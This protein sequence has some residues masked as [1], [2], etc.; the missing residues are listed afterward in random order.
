[1]KRILLLVLVGSCLELYGQYLPNNSQAFQFSPILNPGFSGIENFNDLKLSYRYQWTSFGE[2]SPTFIN[3]SYNTRIKKP[4]DLSYN[5]IRISNSAIAKVPRGKRIIHG[6]AGHLFQSSVGVIESLGAGATYAFHYPI[7]NQFRV[8]LGVSGFVENRRLNI[9]E[10]TVRDPDND[11]FYNHLLN[12]S[13]SQTDLNV[14]AGLL[15]YTP[16]FYFGVS[17]LPLYYEAIQSSELAFEEPFYMATAMIGYAIRVNPQFILK[18]SAVAILQVDQSVIYDIS[19]KAYVQNKVWAGVTYRSVGTGA[20]MIGFNFNER[21]GVSYS[22]EIAFGEF[23]QFSGSSHELV[24]GM[25]LKNF[26]KQ[27]QYTW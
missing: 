19:V 24:L 23:Q 1:M 22:Y 12:S 17:Y 27:S 15:L 13:T 18:P 20:G 10:V 3:L 6:F 2:F 25:K 5:S 11:T 9:H 7:V 4:V 8:S 14:R 26:R 16:D 21:F